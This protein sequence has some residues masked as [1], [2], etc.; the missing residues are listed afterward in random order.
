MAIAPQVWTGF[1]NMAVS[2]N[3]RLRPNW[4]QTQLFAADGP[5]PLEV[6][7]IVDDQVCR[8]LPNNEWYLEMSNLELLDRESNGAAGIQLASNIAA[9]RTRLSALYG[10]AWQA[11]P[12]TFTKVIPTGG[13]PGVRW[14]AEDLEQGLHYHTLRRLL[15]AR[16]GR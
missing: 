13:P 2:E 5:E 8:W 11:A 16:S 4:T 6:D 15:A 9:E 3:R 12:L 1:E 10:A 14:Y 7:H